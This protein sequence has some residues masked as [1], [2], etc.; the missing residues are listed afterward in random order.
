MKRLA[1][2]FLLCVAALTFFPACGTTKT[3]QI[4]PDILMDEVNRLQNLFSGAV[5]VPMTSQIVDQ[6]REGEK[7]HL[8]NEI[9][10][11]ISVNVVFTNSRAGD[12]SM[13]VESHELPR[14]R[15]TFRSSTN[16]QTVRNPP[17][18]VSSLIYQEIGVLT[19]KEGNSSLNQQ[20][21]TS[22]DEGQL[23]ALNPRGDV[24]EITY[25]ARKIVLGFVLDRE[26]GWYDLEFAVEETNRE[27]VPLIIA[28][29][30]PR[31]MI[32]YQTVTS[33]GDTWVQMDSANSKQMLPPAGGDGPVS[34]PAPMEDPP[35][36]PQL[37]SGS[38]RFA[39]AEP[40]GP[41]KNAREGE[42]YPA[43][44]DSAYLEN[45][46]RELYLKES[47]PTV[48][49]NYNEA[50]ELPER[51]QPIDVKVVIV[52]EES[53]APSVEQGTDNCYIIQ[54]G[55]FREKQ[56][57]SLAFAA[58]ERAGFSPIYEPYRNLTRVVIPAVERG[59][60]TWVKEKVKALGF[61]DPYVR[62]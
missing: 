12:S 16:S 21:I 39:D 59:N 15:R 18:P 58:L 46:E 27:Q 38:A 3:D 42:W 34:F 53:A 62:R 35:E 28:G 31:L 23:K 26:K 1:G 9:K 25:P 8:L 36:L 5:R 54:V 17:P 52:G 44:D 19:F 40:P 49:G 55:A 14:V 30:R 20:R 61:G 57:A 10:Y 7:E 32:N 45:R 22:T 48:W 43:A 56:N 11:F 37:N 33:S 51:K 60:L 4:D 24:F 41:G 29:T 47:P 13:E 6:I 2:F 50:P